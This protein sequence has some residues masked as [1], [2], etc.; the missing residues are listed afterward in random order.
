[1]AKGRTWTGRKVGAPP[2][3]EGFIWHTREL[4]L[5]PA[6]RA[7]SINCVR[8]LEF[9]EIEHLA[10]GGFENGSLLAPFDQFKRFG[11]TRRLI[12][13]A[14]R[15]AERLGLVVVRRGKIRGQKQPKASRYKLTY[16]WTRTESDGV[17]DWHEPSDEWK[18][19]RIVSR[20]ANVAIIGSRRDTVTGSSVF[21]LRR[22]N[23]RISDAV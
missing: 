5:S 15:E 12:P 19:Y 2:E 6:W 9:L 1:M 11:I 21:R 23:G 7:R 13:E 8:L 16:L 20:Q 22:A 18:R 4:L 14:I 3:G 17:K 10:H